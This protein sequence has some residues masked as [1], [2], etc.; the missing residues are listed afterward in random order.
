MVKCQLGPTGNRCWDGVRTVNNLLGNNT[1]ETKRE[2]SNWEKEASDS[3]TDLI[4]SASPTGASGQRWPIKGL[5]CGVEMARPLDQRLA[6]SLAAATLGRKAEGSLMK[7]NN[8][9]RLSAHD[10]PCRRAMFSFLKGDLGRASLC[11]P[12]ITWPVTGF[13]S[14]LAPTYKGLPLL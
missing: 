8:T 12:E 6:Q 9:W 13:V 5:P 1:W 11:L 4:E 2:D 10:T 14:T 3:S 7:F